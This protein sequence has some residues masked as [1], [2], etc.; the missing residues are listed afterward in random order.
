MAAMRSD[1]V[2]LFLGGIR[3]NQKHFCA[4]VFVRGGDCCLLAYERA[5]PAERRT[6]S[7]LHAEFGCGV[8]GPLGESLRGFLYL[9]VRELDEEKSDSRGPD[10]LERLRKTL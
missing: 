9:F 1:I 4:A 3:E 7:S 8:D 10:F 2:N 5:A 6:H